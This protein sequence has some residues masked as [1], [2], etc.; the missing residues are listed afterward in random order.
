MIN[1]F[2]FHINPII[3]LYII[4][5]IIDLPK[6]S[7]IMQIPVKI[8]HNRKVQRYCILEQADEFTT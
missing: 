4:E 6:N 3:L 8:H 7:D 5:Q 1:L 2:I